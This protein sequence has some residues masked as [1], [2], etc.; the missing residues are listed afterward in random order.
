[1][2]NNKYISY[3]PIKIQYN[4]NLLYELYKSSEGCTTLMHHMV[5]LASVFDTNKSILFKKSKFYLV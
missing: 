5:S 3:K 4:F 1:M 2:S